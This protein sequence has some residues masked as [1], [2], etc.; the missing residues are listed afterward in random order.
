MREERQENGN[1]RADA[2]PRDPPA[3]PFVVSTEGLAPDV[4]FD[5]WQ[6][7]FGEVNDIVVDRATRHAFEA[8]NEN[9]WLGGMLLTR[10]ATP[11]MGLAR[12]AS[13]A[14]RDGLDHRVLRV[15]RSGSAR[16]RVGERAFAAGPG[17]LV[18]ESLATGFEDAW[19]PSEWVSLNVSSDDEPELWRGL[20]AI[21]PGPVRTP[22]GRLLAD[23][24]L[25]LA[26]RMDEARAADLATLADATRSMVAA[27]LL[28][29]RAPAEE[30]RTGIAAVQ[31]R[32]AEA[33]IREHV[34]SA[35][36]GPSRVADLAGLSR[37]ALYRLFEDE[38]GVA[39]YI[40]RVRLDG[41][42]ADLSDPRKQG[43]QIAEI[44]ARWGFHNVSAFNRTFRSA[45]G[46]APG[47]V[48]A[49]APR[50]RRGA[51]RAARRIPLAS[52]SFAD[53]LR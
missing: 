4:R 38:G 47:E 27:C 45:F 50:P 18:V 41:V 42:L 43:L 20:A 49:G 34:A 13:A 8:R 6:A 1:A 48:R 12:S 40:R 14:R 5:A 33:A 32:R 30:V 37:S 21:E 3:R 23:Y 44:A 29:D 10:N 24:L 16:T 7:F 39:T 2:A 22:A 46:C 28:K 19:D 36:L 26:I 51:E 35:R 25:S 11:R 31:R 52:G 15:A 9:W 53:L 17:D